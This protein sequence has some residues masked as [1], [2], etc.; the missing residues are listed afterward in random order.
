M[1]RTSRLRCEAVF[2]RV[3]AIGFVARVIGPPMGR[4]GND[5]LVSF[6]LNCAV[7]SGTTMA[8]SGIPVVRVD[9]S[10]ERGVV[11]APPRW[12]RAI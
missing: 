1:V 2:A 4:A 12:H 3:P 8:T 9:P 6:A 5:D 10:L 7:H 11:M